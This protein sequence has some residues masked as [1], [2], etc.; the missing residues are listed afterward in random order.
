[1]QRLTKTLNVLSFDC[2]IRN[3]S[4]WLL[5]QSEEGDR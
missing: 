1:M 2:G 4:F 3:L 5:C